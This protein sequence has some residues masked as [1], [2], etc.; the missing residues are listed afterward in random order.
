MIGS[1]FKIFTG[2]KQKRE[3]RQIKPA[4]EQYKESPYAKQQL[5][6]ATNMFN[7][8]MAGLREAERGIFAAQANANAG[9]GRN[10]TDAS[11]ALLLNAAGQGQ[12]NDALMGLQMK[13]AQNKYAMLNNLNN[14]YGAMTQEGDKVYQS[15]LQ[16]YQMD[17]AQKNALTAAGNQNIFGG[18]DDIASQAI[19]I[20]GMGLG[21]GGK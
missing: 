10:A 13:N 5:G 3:A 15:M 7:G 4:W 8:P 21:G 20:A 2:G 1:I 16:K 17:V 6:T 14:A 12:T 11:Q 9:V 18:L 19:Q